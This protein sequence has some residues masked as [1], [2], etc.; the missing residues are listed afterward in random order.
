M[1]L[2]ARNFAYHLLRNLAG[3]PSVRH[4]L[5]AYLYLTYR[6]PLACAYCNDGLGHKYPD[7][8]GVTELST[9]QWFE[10][11]AILRRVTDFLTVTGGEP[12]VRPDLKD[13]LARARALRYRPI[14]LLTNGLRL[15]SDPGFLDSV[16]ILAVSLDTM[17]STKGDALMGKTGAHAQVVQNVERLANRR[18]SRPFQLCVVACILPETIADANAV[19][20]FA[21]ARGIGFAPAPASA[22]TTPVAGLAGNPQYLAFID[23]LIVLKRAGHPILGSLALLDGLRRFRTYRCLPTLLARVKPDGELLYPCSKLYQSAGS[24]L[25]YGDYDRTV[26]EG[27]RRHGPIGQCGQHCHDGCYMDYSLLVQEPIRL[28]DEIWRRAVCLPVRGL[29]ARTSAGRDRS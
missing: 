20:D 19:V 17:D 4:P 28:L 27:V 8:P 1:L 9:A 22:G 24:L 5:G 12:T 2:S 25:E 16:D 18:Q 14:V 7:K 26:A 13:I 29:L 21:L 3:R 11:L 6:C 15:G 23:R 10:V